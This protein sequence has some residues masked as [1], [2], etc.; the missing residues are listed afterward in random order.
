MSIRLAIIASML[1]LAGCVVSP[2]YDSDP[3][4]FSTLPETH[5]VVI[6]QVVNMNDRLS[7][8]IYEWGLFRARRLGGGLMTWL[9]EGQ[10]EPLKYIVYP[11]YL[12]I[13]GTTFW[14]GVLPAGNYLA[15]DLYS[16]FNTGN[17]YG[18]MSAPIPD[19]FASFT[20][21]PGRVTLLDAYLYNGF[22]ETFLMSNVESADNLL[23]KAEAAFPAIITAVD[24]THPLR[25]PSNSRKDPV[26]AF[27]DMAAWAETQGT[28]VYS[29]DGRIYRPA[30]LGQIFER[31]PD[32]EWRRI[33][34]DTFEAVPYVF[35]AANGEAVAVTQ[36]G[37][38]FRRQSA[39]AGFVEIPVEFDGR[40]R[41]LIRTGDGEWIAAVV[42]TRIEERNY[43]PDGKLVVKE[44]VHDLALL[45]SANIETPSWE[46]IVQVPVAA[47][48]ARALFVPGRA[49][50]ANPG[51]VSTLID[52]A[53]G[54]TKRLGSGFAYIRAYD[55]GR[56]LGYTGTETGF[57]GPGGA[58]EIWFSPDNGDTWRQFPGFDAMGMPEL[59]DDGS[60][61]T[62][63]VPRIRTRRE[64]L[65]L[66]ER[67]QG[68][69][70]ATADSNWWEPV[71]KLPEECTGWIELKR[72]E[73][74][75]L[76]LCEFKVFRR[77]DGRSEWTLENMRN[78]KTEN[79]EAK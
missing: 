29:P 67:F 65:S 47:R 35:A 62:V 70:T 50:I 44:E 36:G 71:E 13:P 39:D 78:L 5:G 12:A 43:G 25:F 3:A 40:L 45:K 18:Y 77:K 24:V 2:N 27:D 38:V 28:S 7:P 41:N 60:V 22:G 10:K 79:D 55:D 52:L 14:V 54:S 57:F 69:L 56:I 64:A 11:D 63:G 76:A 1:V 33:A 51:D 26:K 21:E 49:I 73:S 68:I 15:E 16:S 53:T 66:E 31:L 59:L 42:K 23:A 4:E 48:H 32:G 8:Y 20:I 9:Q 72:L 6:F 30:R 74:G 37:R 34:L 46:H 19:S 61:L 58:G 75:L 17:L